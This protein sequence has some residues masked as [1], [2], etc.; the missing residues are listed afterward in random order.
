MALLTKLLL[1]PASRVYLRGLERDLGVS[2]NTVRLELN[3]LQE[4]H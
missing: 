4:M 1:N 3:K 2:S